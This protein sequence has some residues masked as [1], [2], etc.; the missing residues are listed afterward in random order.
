MCFLCYAATCPFIP[1]LFHI[2]LFHMNAPPSAPAMC[3]LVLFCQFIYGGLLLLPRAQPEVSPLQHP[4][5]PLPYPPVRICAIFSAPKQPRPANNVHKKQPEKCPTKPRRNV[6][7]IPRRVLDEDEAMRSLAKVGRAISVH[8]K[9]RVPG[10]GPCAS[11]GG[12]NLTSGHQ[13]FHSAATPR[14]GR[15]EGGGGCASP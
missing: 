3:S 15:Q 12:R 14:G 9:L 6:L 10:P 1:A 8:K 11:G 13:S 4:P 2:Y 7:K 5:P